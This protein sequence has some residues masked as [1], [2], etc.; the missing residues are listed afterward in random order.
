MVEVF[1]TN[2]ADRFA[3]DQ[4][5]QEIQLKFKTYQANF[6]LE[7][8][9]LILRI[10]S[11]KDV[12]AM[13]VILLLNKSGFEASVLPDEPDQDLLLINTCLRYND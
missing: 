9:D 8:C 5:V 12:D 1:K 4:L 6:H 3:A 11:A 7:D 2:V 13:A 10:K